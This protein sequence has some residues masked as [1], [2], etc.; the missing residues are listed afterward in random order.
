MTKAAI[1]ETGEELSRESSD[2]LQSGRRMRF[3]VRVG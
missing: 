2:H 3:G 1:S